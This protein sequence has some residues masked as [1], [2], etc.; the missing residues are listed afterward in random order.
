[1][2]AADVTWNRFVV[3]PKGFRVN[4]GIVSVRYVFHDLFRA[5]A[6]LHCTAKDIEGKTYYQRLHKIWKTRALMAL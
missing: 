5:F 4:Y 3:N 1:V 6:R 2:K